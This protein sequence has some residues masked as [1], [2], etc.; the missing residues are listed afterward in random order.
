MRPLLAASILIILY[1]ICAMEAE[2]VE[3]H[4]SCL[5]SKTH[6]E[7]PTVENNL[8]GEVLLKNKI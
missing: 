4:S 8:H 3:L 1:S 7:Q 2:A 5:K 6:K